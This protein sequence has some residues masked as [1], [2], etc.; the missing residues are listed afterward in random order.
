[1]L[2]ELGWFSPESRELQGDLNAAKGR[3]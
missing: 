1:M 3:L 2:K